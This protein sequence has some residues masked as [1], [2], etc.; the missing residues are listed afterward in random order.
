[1]ESNVPSQ[2]KSTHDK[3]SQLYSS[4][5]DLTTGELEVQELTRNFG[6]MFG[7]FDSEHI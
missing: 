4:N 3:I 7:R 5:K 6:R 2:L 1:M